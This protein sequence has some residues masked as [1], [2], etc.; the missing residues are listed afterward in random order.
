MDQT[1]LSELK[2]SIKGEV[3]T[4]EPTLK[5]Y[6][7]DA[8][9]FELKPEVVVSPKDADDVKSVV[10]FVNKNKTKHPTLSLTP[11]SAGTDMSGGVLSESVVLAFTPHMNKMSEITNQTVKTQPGVYYRDFEKFTLKNNLL[12]PA[13]P[14]SGDICAI[15][16][17]IGNNC[18]GEKSLQYGK[19]DRYVKKMKMVLSDGQEYEFE[20]LDESGLKE[21]LSTTGFEGDLYRKI[22]GLINENYDLIKKAKP[23]VSKNSS[24]YALWNIYNKETKT[25]DLTKLFVG[26]QGTLGIMTETTLNLVPVKKHSEMVV[27]YMKEGDIG[28]LGEV[29]NTVLPFKPE[30]FETYDDNTLKLAIKYF[31]EFG[32]KMGINIFSTVLQFLPEFWMSLT[33]TV[34]KLILQAEFTGDDPKELMQKA[35]ELT[36]KLKPFNLKVKLGGNESKSLKYWLIRRK[37]FSLLKDKI[38][39]MHASPFIDDFAVEPKYLTEFLP[40]LN[41][42][43]AKYPSIILTVA[44]HIG[45]GNFHIIP[46]VRLEEEKERE[47]IKNLSREV[48]DLVFEYHGSTSGEHNDGLIRT[49]YLKAM[50][51]EE[52]YNLFVQTKK[53]FD[54][55]NIFNPG[56]KINVS[57]DY[58]MNHIRRDWT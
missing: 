41:A 36:D 15:G 38:K 45:D 34:P 20:Q 46:L 9:I 56:K 49:P 28:K 44:G 52:I 39:N 48:F 30:S 50:F 14:V 53:I 29:I 8:S 42:L 1:L 58:F 13:Y 25:F 37:S 33:G 23:T 51:G 26:S 35:R 16:G 57:M 31:A 24:G 19:A 22:Y 18:G 5:T 12:F 2:D 21:K 10:G 7:H 6:S 3:L 43:L 17:M 55:D 54:P 47:I 27:I 11:R 4:D 40:K 32:K